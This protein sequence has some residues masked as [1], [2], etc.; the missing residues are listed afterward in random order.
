MSKN[1]VSGANL[2]ITNLEISHVF[3]SVVVP[4]RVIFFPPGY[5]LRLLKLELGRI[6]NTK[7]QKITLH[8]SVHV[9]TGLTCY[10]HIFS[11]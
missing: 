2:E 1:N 5:I 9:L 4:I 10:F 8:L 6:Q 11:F 7:W 3:L